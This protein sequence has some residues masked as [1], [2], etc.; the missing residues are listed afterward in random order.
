MMRNNVLAKHRPLL[1]EVLFVL[2]RV[3]AKTKAK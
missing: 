3:S 2:V 1:N